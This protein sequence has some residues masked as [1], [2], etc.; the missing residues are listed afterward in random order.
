MAVSKAKGV[1]AHP[2]LRGEHGDH[3][4]ADFDN[5]GSSPLTRGARYF[6]VVAGRGGGLIPAYAGSTR[7]LTVT[8]LAIAAHPRLRGEHQVGRRFCLFEL[9]SSPLTRGAR[10]TAADRFLANGLIPAYAGSTLGFLRG[11]ISQ[12]AHPRLRGEHGKSGYRACPNRGSSPLTR[13]ARP[14]TSTAPPQ[15]GLIPA[16]A[17]STLPTSATVTPLSAHPRLRGEHTC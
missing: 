8:T 1:R 9:G 13:G 5:S 16:Y 6:C 7:W 3:S 11:R 15:S 2:R 4:I 12:R 17:G 10:R 14:C